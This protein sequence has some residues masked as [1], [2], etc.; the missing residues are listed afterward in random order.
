[1]SFFP[2]HP[3]QHG[4]SL[5]PRRTKAQSLADDEETGVPLPPHWAEDKNSNSNRNKQTNKQTKSKGVSTATLKT[6]ASKPDEAPISPKRLDHL[7]SSAVSVEW[8]RISSF[9]TDKDK[10]N[11]RKACPAFA[12]ARCVALFV[13][14]KDRLA[15]ALLSVGG[16]AMSWPRLKNKLELKRRFKIFFKY[17]STTGIES[18]TT[19]AGATTN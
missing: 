16:E 12:I 18:G 3:R 6:A 15:D 14:K 1:M 19:A 9:L 11:L 10:R 17:S 13:Y 4:Y 8:L 7:L 5:R 2:P